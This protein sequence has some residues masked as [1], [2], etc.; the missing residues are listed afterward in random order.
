MMILMAFMVIEAGN[1]QAETRYVSDVL[2][3]TLRSGPEK[4]A[5]E[6]R[7]LRSNTPL[8]VIEEYGEY[9]KVRT[10]RNEE[11][12]VIKRYTTSNIPKSMVI[13]ELGE[14][15]NQLEEKNEELD[16][17]RKDLEEELNEIKKY[18]DG[19]DE[20]KASIKKEREGAAK[21]LRELEAMTKKYN[22]LRDKSRNV[23]EM[24]EKIKNLEEKIIKLNTSDNKLKELSEK[25]KQEKKDLLRAGIIRWF[26]AGSGVLFVGIILGKMSRKKDYY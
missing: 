7:T 23:I 6:I 12:W 15:I 14:R 2:V 25:L 9:L 4:D 17:I 8:E 16:K 22:A 19:S 5:E 21:A 26:L 10:E 1:A 20:Y 11:G 13:T 3:I 18:Q 24:S